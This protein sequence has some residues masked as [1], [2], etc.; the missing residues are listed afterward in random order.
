ME[1]KI[2]HQFFVVV[3]VFIIGYLFKSWFIHQFIIG[4]DWSYFYLEY[5]S[6]M[7]LLPQIWMP[8]QQNG[9][10]GLNPILNLS[11]FH[12]I[13]TIPSIMWPH[14]PWNISYKIFWFGLFLFTSFYSSLTFI[15]EHFDSTF[16]RPWF[17]LAPL[18]YTTNTYVLM[19]V[20]GGQMGVALAYAI[21]PLVLSKV[22]RT[23]GHPTFKYICISGLILGIQVMLDPRIAYISLLGVGIYL[24][25][26][27]RRDFKKILLA[28]SVMGGIAVVL[29]AFWIVPL[30]FL[31]NNPLTSLGPEYTSQSAVQFFSFTDFSHTFGLLQPNW[32]ENIFGKTYFLQPE[33][34]LLP[35]LAFISFLFLQKSK[36]SKKLLYVGLLAIVGAFLSKGVKDPFGW[37]YLWMYQHVPG[38][39]VFRD[40]TKFYV[41]TAIGY[42]VL[43]P[44]SIAHIE[45]FFMRTFKKRHLVRGVLS[46]LFI[47]CWLSFIREATF[48]QLGGTFVNHEVP[49]DFIFLKDAWLLQKD[50]FRTLWIP[51]Q[52]R[53]SYYD[54]N[55]RAMESNELFVEATSSSELSKSLSLEKVREKM[56]EMS[57]KYII[58]PIDSLGEIFLED[59]RYSQAKRDHYISVLDDN[60][61]KKIQSTDNI[62]YETGQYWDLFHVE[63][64]ASFSFKNDSPNRYIV[65]VSI[66]KPS[67]LYFSESYQRG[68]VAVE[69]KR[70]VLE[71]K[72]TEYGLNSFELT[73][74][75]S[76]DLVVYFEPQKYGDYGYIISFVS[77]C[78]ILI[79]IIL[80]H[81]KEDEYNG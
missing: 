21:A 5:L 38:F 20:G 63:G 41:L 15:R 60:G 51:R 14:I 66:A 43:I 76:Y 61:F 70:N 54:P 59:R 58:V 10:G 39:A 42:S 16:T 56:K 31:R 81:A 47:V 78:T 73:T 6:R 52:S 40:P 30:I 22:M 62:I 36:S 35:I 74:I 19:V 25:F 27:Q 44:F 64:Q 18:L 79:S 24:F 50:F 37:P 12:T 11:L 45:E 8:L 80:V 65:H 4:G 75:G 68:W 55:H 26:V 67:V 7:P 72:R 34:L 77:F 57:I 33:F 32:P 13:T 3:V 29:N 17:I 71:S 28:L 9:L 46:I 23:L 2:T 49:Q 48:G 53:F 1:K 69:A